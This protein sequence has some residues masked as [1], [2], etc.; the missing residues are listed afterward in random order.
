MFD[1]TFVALDIETTGTIPKLH[2]IIEIGAVKVSKGIIIERFQTMVKPNNKIPL[3]IQNLTNITDQMVAD[4]PAPEDIIPNLKKFI[5]RNPI[6]GHN[7][8]FDLGFINLYLKQPF[9]NKTY[10]TFPLARILLPTLKSHSLAKLTADLNIPHQEKHRAFEDAAATAQLFLHFAEI[11]QTY[12]FD[13]L[14][15]IKNIIGDYNWPGQVF[16]ETMV[17]KL[18]KTFPENKVTDKYFSPGDQDTNSGLFASAEPER[19]D[20]NFP[21]LLDYQHMKSLLKSDGRIAQKFPGFEKRPQQ[22]KVLLDIC[23]AYNENKILLMEAGTGAGKSLSYLIPSIYWSVYNREKV[24]IATHTINLQEQ[25]WH[26]DIPLLKNILD[27]D[28]RIAL[29]KGRN[30]YI[31]LRKWDDIINDGY[32]QEEM[33]FYLRLLIWLRTTKTGDK[34][35][36]N[37]YQWEKEYW[38]NVAAES[39]T[40]LGPRCPW[41]D[42]H[43][44]VMH[45]RRFAESADLLIV[46]HSLLFADI[47]TDNQVLPHFNLLIID[48]AHHLEDGATEHLGVEV[49]SSGLNRLLCSLHKTQS[50]S[51]PGILHHLK[52]KLNK[53]L[54][55]FDPN[56]FNHILN[57]MQL[58][59]DHIYSIK[60]A[61][62]L[63]FKIISA[64]AKKNIY[65]NEETARITYRLKSKLTEENI[66]PEIDN[67]RANLQTRVNYLIENL[68]KI[69]KIIERQSTSE[70]EILV[71][72]KKELIGIISNL[73]ETMAY[74]EMI[75]DQTEENHVYWLDIAPGYCA[76]RAAPI[77]VGAIIYSNLLQNM[78]TVIFSSATLA[79]DGDFAHFIERVGLNYFAPDKFMQTCV[80]S[81]FDYEKQ[82]LLCAVSDLPEPVGIDDYTYAEAIVPF[83]TDLFRI[84]KGLFAGMPNKYVIPYKG[85]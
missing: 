70:E 62:D 68:K 19:A 53:Y 51:N 40:C 59:I 34:S 55:L 83:L 23:Q 25:L 56:D 37:L 38:S 35:E 39:E 67:Q 58:A 12:D 14:M 75:V 18:G 85:V 6:I 17:K 73:K 78:K 2:E 30:N 20:I 1:K 3:F 44:F 61:A 45:A 49:S 72:E 47:K 26:K 10:D 82:A 5:G 15:D 81:P 43:C 65:T 66:W 63:F 9:K 48:E 84:T 22:E 13:L 8:D 32:S 16:I 36:L 33:L 27:F 80:N 50:N 21:V 31:C 28:F 4:A 7:I 29:V 52:N 46:N 60:E 24:V 54:Y 76:L 42:N 77:N 79:I 69:I 41:Y 74:I 57:E 71:A 64:L 11:V